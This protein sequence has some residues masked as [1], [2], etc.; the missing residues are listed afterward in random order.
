[1]LD[2]GWQDRPETVPQSPANLDCATT[3]TRGPLLA[4]FPSIEWAEEAIEM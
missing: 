2:E 1:M 3:T 4:K